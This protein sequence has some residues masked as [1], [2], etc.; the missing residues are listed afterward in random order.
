MPELSR[1]VRPILSMTVR[2]SLPLITTDIDVIP[3][4]QIICFIPYWKIRNIII[5]VQ[6]EWRVNRQPNRVRLAPVSGIPA[7]KLNMTI[8][9]KQNTVYK[10]KYPGF[11]LI[12]LLV[13]ISI[14]GI[15]LGV[16]LTSYQGTRNT[17]RDGRRKADLESI[18]SSIEIYRSDCGV[19]P[20]QADMNNFLNGTVSSLTG[21]S[22]NPNCAGNTYMSTTPTDPIPAKYK[23]VYY[24][25]SANSYNL[26]AYLEDPTA[27]A[28]TNCGSLPGTY[29]NCGK[30]SSA[31]CNYKA[32]QT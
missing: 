30:T 14:I 16:L 1:P 3:H 25:I 31:N 10:K 28:Q 27:V 18:K 6:T 5:F 23:Y 11:T 4:R 19:Y 13:V 29:G 15:L 9:I 17:A 22:T 2:E 21:L 8:G 26:C 24:L 32:G 20:P 7:N 12:E